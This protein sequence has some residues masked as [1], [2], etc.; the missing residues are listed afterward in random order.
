M[1]MVRLQLAQNPPF[2]WLRIPLV[3]PTYL[4][5]RS[6]SSNWALGELS[7]RSF[8]IFTAI[9]LVTAE[10]KSSGGCQTA[11]RLM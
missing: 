7:S 6:P 1:R 3:V 4:G 10:Q 8:N 5:R 2:P 9:V 11:S